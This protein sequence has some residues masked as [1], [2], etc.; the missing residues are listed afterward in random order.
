MR[1]PTERFNPLTSAS[2]SRTV[3]SPPDST[4]RTKKIAASVSGVR[5]RWLSGRG[6][7]SLTGGRSGDTRVVS[8]FQ[9]RPSDA[10]RISS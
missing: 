3:S 5:I 1:N 8:Q 6:R 2:S 7:A 9:R 10:Y 4:V